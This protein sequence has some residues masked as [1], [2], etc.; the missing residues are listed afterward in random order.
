M[1]PLPHRHRCCLDCRQ[2][3]RHRW[4]CSRHCISTVFV[5]TAICSWGASSIEPAAANRR[6]LD[7]CQQSRH[8]WW[9]P[10][11]H[12]RIATAF[13]LA[14]ICSW[15]AGDT[16]VAAAAASP[17]PSS[18]LLSAVVAHLISQSPLHLTAFVSTAICSWGAGG[19]EPAAASPPL[20]SRL[21]SAVAAQVALQPP[22]H[23]HGLRPDCDLQLGRIWHRNRRR[24]ATAVV[25]TAVS[26]CATNGGDIAAASP[27]P[28]SLLLSAVEAQVPSPRPSHHHRRSSTAVDSC[29]KNGF[30][31]ISLDSVG[32]SRNLLES[33]GIGLSHSESVRIR[34][35]RAL[36]T[37]GWEEG[38]SVGM[39]LLIRRY[40]LLPR[41]RASRSA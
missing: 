34:E 41:A 19:I 31:E 33:V 10:R 24:I 4:H 16:G 9:W 38:R 39:N 7:C 2:Q 37:T 27:L 32:I 17:P 28:S 21:P 15:G 26:S 13:V 35:W 1:N 29:D 20:L 36:T 14:A 22:L 11:R 30:E 8:K 12:R 25:S 40:Q 6:G 18:R 5:P 3:S 23:I